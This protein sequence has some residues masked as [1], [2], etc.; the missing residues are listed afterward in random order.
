MK[1][2]TVLPDEFFELFDGDTNFDIVE[3]PKTKAKPKAVP[4]P[5]PAAA[6]KPVPKKEPVKEEPVEE[7]VKEPEVK[8]KFFGA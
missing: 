5:A 7:P 3:A 8:K 1:S 4:K 6:P 2:P